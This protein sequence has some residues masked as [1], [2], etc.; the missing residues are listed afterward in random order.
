MTR[1]DRQSG[2][3]DFAARYGDGR[4]LLQEIRLMASRR[5]YEVELQ[6][7]ARPLTYDTRVIVHRRADFIGER[8]YDNDP[9][10]GVRLLALH[11]RLKQERDKVDLG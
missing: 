2:D 3:L 6:Y 1:R 11:R 10:Y 8:M 7:P 5:S 4:A 9:E